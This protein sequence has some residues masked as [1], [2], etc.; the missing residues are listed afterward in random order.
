MSSGETDILLLQME[1]TWLGD[2]TQRFNNWVGGL[3]SAEEM[4]GRC[5]VV[6]HH[7]YPRTVQLGGE[8]TRMFQQAGYPVF[9]SLNRAA[10]AISR[11]VRLTS[12]RSTVGAPD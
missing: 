6:I 10:T 7:V 3:L 1:M 4:R 11:N 5:A 8:T 9:P 12:G 2:D